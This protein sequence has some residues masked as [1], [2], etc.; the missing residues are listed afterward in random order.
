MADAPGTVAEPEEPAKPRRL[1]LWV[2]FAAAAGMLASWAGP[3]SWPD[4]TG[5]VRVQVRGAPVVDAPIE[6]GK[7]APFEA[8]GEAG[9]VAVTASSAKGAD[10]RTQ[11]VLALK[12]EA[13]AGA[14]PPALADLRAVLVLPGGGEEPVPV[15]EGSGGSFTAKRRPPVRAKV[16]LGLL[17][18]VVILWVTEAVPL[19]V[20]ALFVPVVLVATRASPARECLG[21]FFDPV[22]ALFFG[23]FL[24]AAAARRAGL[25]SLAAR[26]IIAW[27]GRGPLLLLAALM[28]ASM[29]LSLWMSNTAAA[30]L[31]LPVALSASAPLG[32]GF[33]KAAVLGVAYAANA[34]GVGTLVGTPANLL[35]ARF[36]RE[37][38]DRTVTFTDWF[39]YGLP[40]ALLLLPVSGVILW[41]WTRKDLGDASG[42]AEARRAVLAI[43]PAPAPGRW[44]V[45]AVLVATVVLWIT[46]P[47]HGIDAAIV[48]LGAAATLAALNFVRKEDL[49]QLPWEALLLFGSGIA[50]GSA[51]FASGASDFIAVRLEA[52]QGLPPLVA[53]GA[54]AL[55]T[56]LLTAMASNTASAAIVIPLMFPLAGVLGV[57][58][59]VLVITAALASSVDFAL[60]VG[61]PPTMMARATGAVTSREIFR[62]GILVDLAALLILV[63]VLPRIWSALG[64]V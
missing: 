10:G 35:A 58:P 26:S 38:G 64:L 43:A 1:G 9:G 62:A 27:F 51:V 44:T 60:V 25:D 47:A 6:V 20:S 42:F 22:V 40:L 30:A 53:T 46:E 3:A 13:A 61:T 29:F 31:V 11:F 39:G 15:V 7:S 24:A 8:R 28:V 18:A 36:L 59:A 12:V 63:L 23:T 52:L 56:L 34:G 14:A 57:D 19:F 5:R 45:G 32:P 41:G 54:I 33:R 21:S 49:G 2:A 37:Y 4:G 16:V 50:L 17:A 48:G 55:L